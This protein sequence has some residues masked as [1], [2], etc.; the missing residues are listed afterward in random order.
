MRTEYF[1]HTEGGGLAGWG[2]WGGREGCSPAPETELKLSGSVPAWTE[3]WFLL[4]GALPPPL[5]SVDL[6]EP[7][8]NPHTPVI[9]LR[10][11]HLP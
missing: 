8:P 6:K 7:V 11:E 2:G 10:N 3:V 1:R 4:P 5:F 9:V